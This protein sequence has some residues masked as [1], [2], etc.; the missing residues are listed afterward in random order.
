M[1]R[2]APA[3]DESRHSRG[4]SGHLVD[5]D[6]MA[7]RNDACPFCQVIASAFYSENVDGEVFDEDRSWVGDVEGFA[8]GERESKGNKG[9]ALQKG[10][11]RFWIHAYPFIN[12]FST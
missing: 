7:Q 11:Q 3:S 10:I 2:Q 8:G 4:R 6:N 9:F 1:K 5:F 12:D